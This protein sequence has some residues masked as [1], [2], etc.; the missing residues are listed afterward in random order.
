[1]LLIST[2]PFWICCRYSVVRRLAKAAAAHNWHQWCE[3]ITLQWRRSSKQRRRPMLCVMSGCASSASAVNGPVHTPKAEKPKAAQPFTVGDSGIY[4]DCTITQIG[5]TKHRISLRT[6]WCV[7]SLYA[8]NFL[9]TTA[10]G[11]MSE[12]NWPCCGACGAC[13]AC[14]IASL[15][16]SRGAKQ[17]GLDTCCSQSLFLSRAVILFPSALT[18]C[19]EVIITLCWAISF[20]VRTPTRMGAFS[21]GRHYVQISLSPIAVSIQS[22]LYRFYPVTDQVNATDHS[23][24]AIP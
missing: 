19:P 1:M 3:V 8:G 23:L 20:Y 2:Q 13:G 24:P 10:I 18:I 15:T 9:R 12:T 7:L 5:R 14:S 16:N 4:G 21:P 22:L 17:T 6:S 11:R